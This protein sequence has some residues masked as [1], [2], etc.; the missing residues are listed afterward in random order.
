M[1]SRPK[2]RSA[3]SSKRLNNPAPSKKKKSSEQ[4]LDTINSTPDGELD[5]DDIPDM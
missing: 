1:N 5:D 4:K 3:N 2:D